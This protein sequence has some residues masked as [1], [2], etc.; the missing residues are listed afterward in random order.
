MAWI[1]FMNF[2]CNVPTLAVLR[3]KSMRGLCLVP[4]KINEG[5]TAPKRRKGIVYLANLCY[6]QAN[7]APARR[8]T[9]LKPKEPRCEEYR[10]SRAQEY[11]F[12][13]LGADRGQRNEFRW[14]RLV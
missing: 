12:D 9:T 1:C 4:A 10:C 11:P 14:R 7:Q 5:K 13:A 6:N 3:Y 8:R 2:N